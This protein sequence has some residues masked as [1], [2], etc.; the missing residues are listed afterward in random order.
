MSG[1]A[2]GGSGDATTSD[3][4]ALAAFTTPEQV[5]AEIARFKAKGYDMS[6]PANQK[7]LQNLDARKAQ[8]LQQKPADAKTDTGGD[9]DKFKTVADVDAEIKRV[10]ATLP[11]LTASQK[12][13]T[14]S[15]LK[16]LEARKAVLQAGGTPTSGAGTQTAEGNRDKAV[17]ARPVVGQDMKN[18]LSVI[19]KPATQA[20]VDQ[21]N[22][23]FQF[24][25]YPDGKPMSGGDLEL[26]PNWAKIDPG[27]AAILKGIK[28]KKVNGVWTGT[29][30]VKDPASGDMKVA[31]AEQPR[32]VKALDALAQAEAAKLHP[33]KES[34]GYV[35]DDLARIVSLVHH[36]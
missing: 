35:N 5:D 31:R 9:T 33:M 16:S 8:L 20:D 27:M 1:E 7:Y 12:E 26:S 28:V 25:H 36:R 14:Q 11:M 17:G 32:V 21:W 23:N 4:P 19:G 13:S 15:Y 3:L 2:S 18:G 22:K 10:T 29:E 6:Q 24:T 34:V 30:R